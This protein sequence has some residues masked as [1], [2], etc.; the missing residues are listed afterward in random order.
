MG[1]LLRKL[2]YRALLPITKIYQA[3]RPGIRI[4]MYHRV[5]QLGNYDQLT[6]TPSR[7]EEHMAFLSGNYRIIS[8]DRAVDE[9]Q[10]GK[11]QPSVV[12]TFDDGYRDNLTNALPVL[13]KNNIPATI[14]LTTKFCDQT[15]RHPRYL[16][17]MGRLHLNWEE[18]KKLASDPNITIGSH[19]L[20]HPYLS[21]M[22]K[23]M[24]QQE[25]IESRKQI[26][27]KLEIDVNYFCYPSGDFGARELD[28]VQCAGY[29]AAVTVDPGSNRDF[30][31]PFELS[32][33][34]ITNKDGIP[35][36]KAKLSGAFDPI[37]VMLH[38]KRKR[39]LKKA[40]QNIR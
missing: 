22:S 12:I 18:V 4:L 16:R 33:T 27:R 1:G 19:T 6:V 37:H 9:L 24:S 29:K 3:M 23:E 34:E 11:I 31:K 8:L 30:T 36:L 38:W 15:N 5:I 35:E 28:Y 32:R 14:F 10:T 13:Q 40:S 2:L 25:I 39:A 21:R 26:Q 17:E 7:F 20:S